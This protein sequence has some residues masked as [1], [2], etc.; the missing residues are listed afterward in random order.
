MSQPTAT[1]GYHTLT[2]PLGLL[3]SEYISNITVFTLIEQSIVQLSSPLFHA[4][5]Y[6]FPQTYHKFHS[7][8]QLRAL[9]TQKQYVFV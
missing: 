6:I 8:F 9:M 7:S 3:N 2:P 1:Q 4:S 5:T